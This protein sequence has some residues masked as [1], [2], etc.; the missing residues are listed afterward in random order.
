MGCTKT[1]TRDYLHSLQWLTLKKKKGSSSVSPIHFLELLIVVIICGL[2]IVWTFAVVG[3]W[4]GCEERSNPEISLNQVEASKSDF[5]IGLIGSVT[6]WK[7][8]V[9]YIQELVS[10]CLQHAVA[11]LWALLCVCGASVEHL[12]PRDRLRKKDKSS[13]CISMPSS[14]HSVLDIQW[15]QPRLTYSD[16]VGHSWQQC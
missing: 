4:W 2:F 15:V 9:S 5:N 16:Y 12:H 10:Q 13:C 1:T 11:V 3:W 6:D 8:R 14:V 7:L